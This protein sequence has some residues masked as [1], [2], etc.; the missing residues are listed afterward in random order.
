M[1]KNNQKEII[2]ISNLNKDIIKNEQ[3]KLEDKINTRNISED[4]NIKNDISLIKAYYQ[5][6]L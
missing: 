1:N 2:N 6:Y 5:K 3:L 4:K